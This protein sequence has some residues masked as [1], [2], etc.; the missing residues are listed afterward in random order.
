ME[1]DSAA[2]LPFSRCRNTGRRGRAELGDTA[3]SSAELLDSYSLGS[4]V[5]RRPTAI[6]LFAGAGGLDIGLENAGFNI[7]C[8][9][10][11]NKHACAT[12][13]ANQLIPQMT[14]NAFDAWFD[15]V[16]AGPYA[17]WEPEKVNWLRE[18]VR[19]G[20]ANHAY[21]QD[22]TIIERDIG[23]V[24]SQTIMEA[25]R[26]QPGDIDLVVGGPPCQTFSRSGKRESVNDARGQLFMEFARVVR[27]V[28]PRW[29][30]FEN[31]KGLLLAKPTIWKV[32]CEECGS[33]ELPPFDPDRQEPDLAV[34]GPP[35]TNCGSA[36]TRWRIERNKRSGAL[37][38]IVTE[39]ER[40]GYRCQ[41]Y[42]LDAV[43]YGAPQYRERVFIIGSRDNEPF[44]MPIGQYSPVGLAGSDSKNGGGSRRRIVGRRKTVWEAL[45]SEPDPDHHWPLDPEQAVLWVKNV[46]RP[47]DEPVTWSLLR[48]APTI[49]AHQS[50]KLAIA[51]FGVPSE[52]LARQQWHTLGRRQGHTKPVPVVHSYLSD[53]N[54]LTLQTFPEYWFVAGTRMERAF[55]IGNAVPP[56][57]AERVGSA[58]LNVS[59]HS[60]GSHVAP[61]GDTA[62]N[63]QP[64]LFTTL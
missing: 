33:D 59:S 37:E 38:L 27:D 15:D 30:L 63:K 64:K 57:L 7:R 40:I 26:A 8:A 28:R 51:P 42:V 62:K 50:A 32:V 10:D 44:A 49:G 1:N 12:L 54:L 39:F 5:T 29:F 46:V 16:A 20:V 60:E 56:L 47:H 19:A 18:R 6:S 41:C 34:P 3:T 13:R 14:R 53:P 52:Q 23:E 45:F 9:I 48:P 43:D 61:I 25:A 35:C 2:M 21:L 22:C 11:N 4:K 55:Q 58:I 31:V 36:Q 17:R 24:A